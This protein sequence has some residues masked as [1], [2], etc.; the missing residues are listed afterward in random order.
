MAIGSQDGYI[1]IHST[2]DGELVKTLCDPQQKSIYKLH[3]NPNEHS[4][5][6]SVNR[7][8]TM[9]VWD[10]HKEKTL[11][12]QEG[13][14]LNSV[15]ISKKEPH[16]VYYVNTDSAL[17]I[18]DT[19]SNKSVKYS[20]LTCNTLNCVTVHPDGNPVL[21]GTAGGEVLAV[22]LRY[23]KVPS[24]VCRLRREIVSLNY[25]SCVAT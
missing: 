16:S 2:K 21:V 1:R 15:F 14:K 5:L 18:W 23:C 24:V 20:L 4:Q 7:S 6:L 8:G 3:Y 17:G 11:H 22:D 10:L 19:R 9:V 12:Q 25:Q 13:P